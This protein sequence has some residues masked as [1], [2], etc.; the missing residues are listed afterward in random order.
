MINGN[1]RPGLPTA[2]RV[3]VKIYGQKNNY[4]EIKTMEVSGWKIARK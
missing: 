3:S 1:F 2:T 4:K